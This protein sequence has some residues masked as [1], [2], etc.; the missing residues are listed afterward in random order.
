MLLLLLL[1]SFSVA[2]AAAPP[3]VPLRTY[4]QRDPLT[5][6]QFFCDSCPPGTYLRTRCAPSRPSECAP[7]PRGSFTELWNSMDRCLRCSVCERNQVDE[8]PCAADRNRRCRCMD[9]FYYDKSIYTCRAHSE[10]G[11]GEGVCPPGTA[12]EDTRCQQCPSGTFSDS[13]SAR[14]NCTQQR[15]CDA[16]GQRLLLQGAPWH[17]SVCIR[18]EDG[19]DSAICLKEILPAFFVYQKMSLKRLRQLVRR[20]PSAQGSAARAAS[21]LSLQE[22]KAVVRAWV[23]SATSEQIL[24]LQSVLSGTGAVSAGERLQ[25][26]LN[27]IQENLELIC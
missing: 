14:L 1:L 22:L 17:D 26:K 13:I 2:D 15:S 11:A 21:S 9:G 5:G 25:R 10:C 8:E 24:R 20:L 6:H 4:R 12:H 18:C 27:R 16:E 7:C 23:D 19:A 3:G